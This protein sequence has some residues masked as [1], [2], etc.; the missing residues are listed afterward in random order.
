MAL[1][2][3][4]AIGRDDCV[5]VGAMAVAAHGYPRATKD[6]DILTRVPLIEARA[7]LRRA[8]MA[9]E[10]RRGDLQEGDFS[11]IKG[12]SEGIPYDVLPPLVPIEWE[13]SREVRIGRSTLRVVELKT[14]LALKLRAGGPQDLLDVAM[15]L[16]Q[17]PAERRS[18]LRLAEAYRVRV[19]LESL[20]RNPRVLRSHE[21][22]TPGARPEAR[23][24][25]RRARLRAAR[26]SAGSAPAAPRRRSAT[27]RGRSGG[28]RARRGRA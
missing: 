4:A 8:G 27:R 9:A 15:L 13:R 21:A 2:V 23:G 6:V 11:C 25:R 1:R 22:L 24:P 12:S 14:L 10:I 28:R 20:L 19:Q 16:L 18:A 7:R 26:A 3:A 5:L 17:N